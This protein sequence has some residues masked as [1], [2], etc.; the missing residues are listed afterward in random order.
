LFLEEALQKKK[1]TRKAWRS[2]K[3]MQA[4]GVSCGRF[5]LL[6][7][8]SSSERNASFKKEKG[9]RMSAA[10]QVIWE[11]DG[12]HLELNP[13]ECNKNHRFRVSLRTCA[14]T[15]GDVRANNKWR[16]PSERENKKTPCRIKC[17]CP[18]FCAPSPQLPDCESICSC[19]LQPCSLNIRNASVQ[20]KRY[21]VAVVG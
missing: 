17:T 9:R 7:K 12:S 20:S 1:C 14:S 11:V 4:D 18:S 3:M 19:Q 16:Y 13:L 15:S 10:K 6:S 8:L 5:K 2:S 21:C